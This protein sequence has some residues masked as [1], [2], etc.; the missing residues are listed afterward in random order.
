[1]DA[2]RKESRAKPWVI[3]FGPEGNQNWVCFVV[4]EEREPER[5][6]G[7]KHRRT[8]LKSNNTN[9]RRSTRSNMTRNTNNRQL[10][11]N[12]SQEL[13]AE[14]GRIEFDSRWSTSR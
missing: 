7:N 4:I 11:N 12:R 6:G 10:R 2:V 13:R 5:E 14:R 9:I 8:R 3:R 1:M